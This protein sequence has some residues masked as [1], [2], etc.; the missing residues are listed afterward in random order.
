MKSRKRTLIDLQSWTVLNKLYSDPMPRTCHDNNTVE[1]SD[2]SGTSESARNCEKLGTAPRKP[3]RTRSMRSLQ[4]KTIKSNTQVAQTVSESDLRLEELHSELIEVK[5]FNDS[6]YL[7][8][9]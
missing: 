5:S 6:C 4:R 1:P 8:R 2:I 7:T 3:G 9:F